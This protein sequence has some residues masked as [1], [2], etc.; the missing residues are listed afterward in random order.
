MLIGKQSWQ[1]RRR[2]IIGRVE[3]AGFDWW[4]VIVAGVGF[5]TD[6]YDVSTAFHHSL[7]SSN[8]QI[9]SDIRR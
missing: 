7:M 5:L 9:R 8:Q 6:A 4:I 1:E 2:L 3:D